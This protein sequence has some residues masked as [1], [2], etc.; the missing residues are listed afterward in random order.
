M[1]SDSK[2]TVNIGDYRYALTGKTILSMVDY[3]AQKS[4][5]TRANVIRLLIEYGLEHIQLNPVTVER[6]R[7]EF[8]G[9]PVP[10]P[11]TPRPTQ[12][13]SDMFEGLRKEARRVRMERGWRY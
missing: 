2:H 3:I 10:S 5:R 9:E 7:I 13:D 6:Y 1:N 11:E 4:G 12:I 8:D